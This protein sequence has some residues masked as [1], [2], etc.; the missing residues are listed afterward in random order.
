MIKYTLHA[1]IQMQAR[2]ISRL[3]VEAAIKGGSKEFQGKDKLLH[4]YR[5]F[6]VVTR[7]WNQDILVITVKPRW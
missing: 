6:C 4:H 7:K 3:E 2:G 5:Y 1:R